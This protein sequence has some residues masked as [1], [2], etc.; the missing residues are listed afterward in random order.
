MLTWH[1]ISRNAYD[2]MDESLK[3]SDKLFFIK[4]DKNILNG[5]DV[6][7]E[8]IIL[9]NRY[10]TTIISNKVYINI[11]TLEGMVCLGTSWDTIIYPVIVNRTDYFDSC[12]IKHIRYDPMNTILVVT[13]ID[14]TEDTIDFSDLTIDMN[15]S[16]GTFTVINEDCHLSYGRKVK[17]SEFIY[18]FTYDSNAKRLDIA[19]TDPNMTVLGLNVGD[20]LDKA[21]SVNFTITGNSFI[22]ECLLYDNSA[23]NKMVDD[24][25]NNMYIVYRAA[26]TNISADIVT[27]TI[28]MMANHMATIVNT[29]LNLMTTVGFDKAEQIILANEEGNAKASGVKITERIAENPTNKF[30]PTEKAVAEFLEDNAIVKSNITTYEKFQKLTSETATDRKLVSERALLEQLSWEVL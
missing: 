2:L 26:D 24:Y 20:I 4:E 8:D 9:Y 29:N 16:N 19:F 11:N 5:T 15:Y 6:F 7:N 25:L 13:K 17:L 3:T 21:D 30:V 10:P 22:A 28:S 18:T 23:N 12:D 14:D 1:F 27:E